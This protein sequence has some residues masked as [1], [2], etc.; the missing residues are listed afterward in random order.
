MSAQ[1]VWVEILERRDDY[2]GVSEVGEVKRFLDV[3]DLVP[4]A[5]EVAEKLIN[6]GKA[7][8]YNNE[9]T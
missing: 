9:R 2:P 3:G 1:F 8:K 4:L 6:E 7:R 5:P